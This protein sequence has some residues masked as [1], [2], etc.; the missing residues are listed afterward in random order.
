MHCGY[1]KCL[2]LCSRFLNKV[3]YKRRLFYYY[4][5]CFSVYFSCIDGAADAG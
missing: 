3:N 5:G 2:Y 1:E 4:E